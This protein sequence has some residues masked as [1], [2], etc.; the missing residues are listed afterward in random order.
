[1]H[2][3]YPAPDPFLAA[4]MLFYS[5]WWGL[6]ASVFESADGVGQQP[7]AAQEAGALFLVDLLMVPHADGDGVCLANVPD[8]TEVFVST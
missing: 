3:W 7:H 2:D 1:M 6:T 5:V 8:R 4:V